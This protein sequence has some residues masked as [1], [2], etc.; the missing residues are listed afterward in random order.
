[1]V[2]LCFLGVVSVQGFEDLEFRVKI[3]QGLG[4]MDVV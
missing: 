2:W 3:V 1:M 4:F